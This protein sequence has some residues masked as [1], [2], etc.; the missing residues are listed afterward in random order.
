MK[1][2]YLFEVANYTKNKSEQV[3]GIHT[4]SDLVEM[5]CKKYGT[6]F[7]KIVY[8]KD[9]ANLSDNIAIL[10]NGVNVSLT[11]GMD[12]PINDDDEIVFLP[13]LM[14]G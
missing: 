13:P 5:L 11:T 12:T 7:R 10:V 2:Y 8:G 4:L 3:F 14:G 6:D 9:N 1:I